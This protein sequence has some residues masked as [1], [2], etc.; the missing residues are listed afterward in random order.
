MRYDILK[1]GGGRLAYFRR[2]LAGFVLL[3]TGVMLKGELKRVW[4]MYRM[5]GLYL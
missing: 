2:H 5:A 4:S 3:L 1:K